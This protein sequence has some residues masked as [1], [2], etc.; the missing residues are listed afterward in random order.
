MRKF[1]RLLPPLLALAGLLVLSPA[2]M[3][4]DGVGVYGRTDDKV[5]TFFAFGLIAF[6]A[7]F[8]TVLSLIQI[9]LDHRKERRTKD[10]ERLGSR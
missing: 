9:R 10:L 1:S 6:F 3:A 4:A 2:A 8:V 7:I 5:V